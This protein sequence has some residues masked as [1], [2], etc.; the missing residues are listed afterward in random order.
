MNYQIKLSQL[1]GDVGTIWYRKDIGFCCGSEPLEKLCLTDVVVD[2]TNF[3]GNLSCGESPLGD[4]L[5][6]QNLF[7]QGS[8]TEHGYSLKGTVSGVQLPG[9]LAISCQDWNFVLSTEQQKDGTGRSAHAEL[10]GEVV[11]GCQNHLKGTVTW[12]LL[13][14]DPQIMMHIQFMDQTGAPGI[15]VPQCLECFADLFGVS[16]D[17][18]SFLPPG[19]SFETQARIYGF[20]FS[21]ED[22]QVYQAA[23]EFGF[24]GGANKLC[25]NTSIASLEEIRFF[26][27]LEM[28]QSNALFGGACIRFCLFGQK[29]ELLVEYPSYKIQMQIP[30][31]IPLA[32]AAEQAG[33]TLP[34]SMKEVQLSSLYLESELDLFQCYMMLRL[35]NLV[36]LD[37]SKTAFFRMD[38]TDF[39]LERG[40]A[41]FQAGLRGVLALY[42]KNA[43]ITAFLAE[44]RFSENYITFSCELMQSADLFQV[45]EVLTGVHFSPGFTIKLLAMG[46]EGSYWNSFSLTGYRASGMVSVSD[47]A[48]FGAP[49]S[50]TASV[51]GSQMSSVFSGTFLLGNLFAVEAR[52]TVDEKKTDWNFLLVLKNLRVSL[53]YDDEKKQVSGSIESDFLLE[54]CVTWFLSLFDPEDSYAPSGE[55]SFLKGINLKGLTI[56]YC[57]ATNEIAIGWEPS[58]S[59]PF[60]SFDRISLVV[61]EQWGVRF[62]AT[63]EFLGTIYSEQQP[64]SWEPNT[65]P[66]TTGK[67][68]QVQYL[69]LSDSLSV[70]GLDPENLKKSIAQLEKTITPDT[71]PED[72]TIAEQAGYLA[73]LDCRIADTVECKLL[74]D[75][76]D[77]LYGGY[78]RLYGKRAAGFDGLSA[79]L[80][81]G[82]INDTIGMFHVRFVPPDLKEFQLGTLALT[83]GCMDAKIYTN[84]NFYLDVGFP[85]NRDFKSSFALRYGAF[86]GRGGLYLTQGADGASELLPKVKNGYFDHV[87]GVGLGLRLELGKEF[88]AGILSASAQLV[89]Q[90][91]LEGLY[92]VYEPKNST[93]AAVPFYKLSA[94]VSLDGTLTGRVDFGIIGACVDLRIQ[95]QAQLLIQACEQVRISTELTIQA[96]AQVKILFVKVRFGFSLRYSVVFTFAEAS[97]APWKK[98]PLWADAGDLPGRDPIPERLLLP[99]RRSAE[100]NRIQ[101][102]VVPIFSGKTDFYTATLFLFADLKQFKVIAELLME[103]LTVNHYLHRTGNMELFERRRL[104]RDPDFLEH[105][106]AQQVVFEL[107]FPDSLQ[108]TE[109]DGAFLPLPQDLIVSLVSVYDDG[110][111]DYLTAW[112]DR[113]QMIDDSYM[114]ENDRYYQST[115]ENKGGETADVLGGQR[116]LQ[117]QLWLDY[118]ELLVK[119]VRAQKESAALTRKV[120]ASNQVEEDQLRELA[121]IANTFLLSGKRAV[122]NPKAPSEQQKLESV[123]Y[124]SGACQQLNW[125][126]DLFHYRYELRKTEGAP[127]WLAFADN[128][129][130]LIYRI[131]K[132][133]I[134]QMLPA[135]I[136]PDNVF[137]MPLSQSSAWEK[138]ESVSMLRKSFIQTDHSSYYRIGKGFAEGTAYYCEDG[139]GAPFVLMVKLQLLRITGDPALYRATGF[140]DF[141]VV[142]D[143]YRLHKPPAI[144]A[145]S[146]L[147]HGA[148]GWQ[149]QKQPACYAAKGNGIAQGPGFASAQNPE[150]FL[151]ALY[152]AFEEETTVFLGFPQGGCF[153]PVGRDLEIV[154]AVELDSQGVWHSCMNGLCG[155]AN[156]TEIQVKPDRTVYRQVVQQGTIRAKMR[157]DCTGLSGAEGNLAGLLAG[158]AAELRDEAGT[159]LSHETQPFFGQGD[160]WQVDSYI[161]QMPYAKACPENGNSP[162][163]DCYAWIAQ[164][165]QLTLSVFFLDYT[166]GRIGN[167]V[168][169]PFVPRYQDELISPAAW[170]GASLSYE[171]RNGRWVLCYQGD[172]AEQEE[173]SEAVHQLE[174][175]DVT[176]KLSGTILEKESDRKAEM[177]AFLKECAADPQNSHCQEVEVLFR[178]FEYS[179]FVQVHCVISLERAHELVDP[180]APEQVQRVSFQVPFSQQ[181]SSQPG[182][183]LRL[184][185]K[186]QNGVL[187]VGEK[188]A[189]LLTD[190]SCWNAQS[191]YYFACRPLP[192]VSGNFTQEGKTIALQSFSLRGAVDAFVEDVEWIRLPEQ[193]NHLYADDPGGTMLERQ[194]EVCKLASQALA[195]LV[196]PV[197][198]GTP[199]AAQ[200]C[201]QAYAAK[202]MAEGKLHEWKELLFYVQQGIST[203]QTNEP[204]FLEGF[205][206]DCDYPMW[207]PIYKADA[208]LCGATKARASVVDFQGSVFTA[209]GAY[210]QN[211][212][213]WYRREGAEAIFPL[214]DRDH[215][216]KP[217]DECVPMPL[218][219]GK[220][221]GEQK[222]LLL[223]LE[224]CPR[225]GDVLSIGRKKQTAC[226]NGK[227]VIPVFYSYVTQSEQ[228]RKAGTK[229]SRKQL[230]DW[231][232][233]FSQALQSYTPDA[234]LQL[235]GL[236]LT[237][238]ASEG[239]IHTLRAS[240]PVIKELCYQLQ[241][242]TFTP[243]AQIDQTF[244]IPGSE[245]IPE[246][247]R[248]RL[249]IR[250]DA[251][252]GKV[253][254]AVMHRPQNLETNLTAAMSE[255]FV[256]QSEGLQL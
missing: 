78:F 183:R 226:G 165:K 76:V 247:Q 40:N 125:T 210:R 9:S 146:L 52:A 222:E 110:V 71:A 242:G 229:E 108:E 18:V 116:S 148:A 136:L 7:V 92:A 58:F 191:C 96:S 124:L 12:E 22:S 72:L 238:V 194:Y 26:M 176:V 30:F 231:M 119:A 239:T 196:C 63:G 224:V 50:L 204:W 135:Q 2:G 203:L 152:D 28:E 62:V 85:Q 170:S 46:V 88:R 240:E 39:I 106:F 200:T 246:N 188:D 3:S 143:Y 34:G 123:W 235:S 19:V 185:S 1:V 128:A 256:L 100:K 51:M 166:G 228:L 216:K 142:E 198:L 14:E 4:Y 213:E 214:Y 163:P 17:F 102:K 98:N 147:Y 234:P 230:L 174:Q 160:Q 89:L 67:L 150:Q 25:W 80:S 141:S 69:L 130:Q 79:E 173:L 251:A 126:N 177:L 225:G 32:Q 29:I 91:I 87:I 162:E 70:N 144:T 249:R 117:A 154:F 179:D 11:V 95:A 101:L 164:K 5:F 180:Q 211:Q 109:Q 111:E 172:G 245:G 47:A 149:E 190:R 205:G 81:Y 6:L 61:G 43:R 118:W 83:L 221:L 181:D 57:Y 99:L 255:A 182:V 59:V 131:E 20:S 132:Q 201:V 90:G 220:E 10:I 145:L 218:L 138:D 93:E 254:W 77:G 140:Q 175:P 209:H 167:Q 253:D 171:M 84:G 207:L 112:L 115:T 127:E 129:E 36:Q 56:A 159:V 15:L 169:L 68:L 23:V 16:V 103:T 208:M 38:E 233:Q 202:L 192:D 41:E 54:D 137:V 121:G 151:R 104:F 187:F 42:Q 215:L 133:Q 49:F 107:S 236:S 153:L 158:A 73:A 250:L 44:A 113:E 219:L 193:M 33:L 237:F 75:A 197:F 105:L 74:Y 55:W 13:K 223:Y 248:L 157:L 35:S 155:A 66:E 48:L 114:A 86:L 178:K 82:K 8:I 65:P 24:A 232:E 156:Q 134:Q 189:F 199:E 186:E 252:A 45:L 184:K 195:T 37:I 212:G 122:S 31:D 94:W 243:F 206:I 161:L 64:L 217:A 60:C 139:S 241:D 227:D 244:S 97:D 168:S 21:Y 27:G 53:E 120:F